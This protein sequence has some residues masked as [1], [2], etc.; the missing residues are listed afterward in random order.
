[1]KILITGA[2]GF[3]GS[4]LS[5]NLSQHTIHSFSRSELDLLDAVAVHRQLK[6]QQYDAVIHCASRGRNDARSVDSGIV[7]ENLTAWLNLHS[8]R[9]DFGMLINLASGAEFD[10]DKNIDNVNELGIWNSLPTH[11]YGLSKNAIARSVQTTD[12]FYNLS[13]FGCF[14]PSEDN[15]RPLKRLTE[16]LSNGQE[17]RIGQD[18]MFDMVS[19]GDLTTVITAVLDNNIRDKDLNIVYNQKFK[20]SEIMK[21][22][23]ELHQ[24]DYNLI[25]VDNLD[26]N[27]YTGNGSRLAAYNLPLMGLELSLKNYQ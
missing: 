12:N 14:D 17:F 20:L 3:I 5:Q 10:I 7:A 21:M 23:A 24:L 8:N 18:K 6:D 15:R 19:I 11:S 16:Q 13:I 26:S 4:Y 9:H 25:R 27:N 1:M 22:Y 2:G